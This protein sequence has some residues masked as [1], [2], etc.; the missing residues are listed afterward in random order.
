[1]GAEL[2]MM[3]KAGPVPWNERKIVR[4]LLKEFCEAERRSPEEGKEHLS[5]TAE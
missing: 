3:T 2:T 1:M 5:K 4:E